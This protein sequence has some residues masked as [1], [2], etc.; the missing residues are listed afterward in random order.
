MIQHPDGL[1]IRISEIVSVD[2]RACD[3]KRVDISVESPNTQ[4]LWKN[5]SHA[6]AEAFLTEF[7][8]G[9]KEHAVEPIL[10]RASGILSR[11]E[12]DAQEAMRAGTEQSQSLRPTHFEDLVERTA[13]LKRSLTSTIVDLE[14][15]C[16]LA[17]SFFHD[18]VCAQNV[19][20]RLLCAQDTIREI[21]GIQNSLR[22]T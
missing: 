15:I 10:E 14:P 11:A 12:A 22:D 6:R 1:G 8:A 20:E 18:T 3:I 21:D 2:V 5:A 9:W 4:L 16:S 19:A 7:Y 13:Q 17:R